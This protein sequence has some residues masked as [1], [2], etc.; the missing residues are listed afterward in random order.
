MDDL[1]GVFGTSSQREKKTGDKNQKGEMS[2][3]ICCQRRASGER[4]FEGEKKVQERKTEPSLLAPRR[5]KRGWKGWEGRER[6][7]N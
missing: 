4:G 5:C 6:E 1:L 7:E 2:T 3:Y